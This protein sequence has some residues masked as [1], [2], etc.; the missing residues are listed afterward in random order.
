MGNK[1]HYAAIDIGSNAARLLIKSVELYEGTH[2]LSKVQLLRV[3][4]R[5]GE[6]AFTKGYIGKKKTNKLLQLMFAYKH[7][8]S[9]YDVADYRACATSA[10]RDAQNGTDLVALIREQT[11][12][13]IEI[14]DGQE[15]AQLISHSLSSEQD[16]DTKANS[17][18]ID[19][20]GGST[21][22]NLLQGGQL[23]SSQSFDI[24]TI[25]LLNNRVA[26]EVQQ[27]FRLYLQNIK[28]N[29]EKLS[30]VGS[31]GNINKLLRLAKLQDERACFLPYQSLQSLYNELSALSNEERMLRFQLKPDRSDV[32]VPASEIFLLI[33]EILELEG[34]IVPTKGLSDGIIE[35]I[36]FRNHIK[37]QA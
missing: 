27:A 33:G 8:M 32:I 31:G 17:L 18:Y 15:E 26:P 28:K 9:I 1:V 24:G 19:V 29:Y 16:L 35:S 6:D 22:L 30:V 10:M 2:K 34:F 23:V 36:Y 20:G 4:L 37:Q 25:R 11:G 21:E 12:L 13:C 5:L 3:P 14:I 7:L